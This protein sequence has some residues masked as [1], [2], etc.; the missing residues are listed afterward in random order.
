[1]PPWPLPAV[2]LGAAL[3]MMTLAWLGSVLARD[4]S[5]VDVFWGLGFVLVAWV[6]RLGL[7]EHS[8][9]GTLV[10]GLVT[11]WGVRLALH[12]F[13]RG[14]GR[15][16]DYR[17]REMRERRP[18]FFVAW[19]LFMVFWLQAALLW[20]VSLPLYQA[21]R[22]VEPAP[23]GLLDG[24]GL[25]L[26]LVGFA[27]E[28]VGDWQL[29]RFKRDPGNEG[30]VMDRGLWRYTRHP[31]Y[32]GDA[33]VWWGFF[34]FAAATPG[35]WWTVISPVLMTF[36]LLRVSGV[37]LLETRLRETRPGYR[38]YAGRTNA[39]FPWL[40]SRARTPESDR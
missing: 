35:G 8:L 3:A 4:A 20:L 10:V 19:S 18:R 40:P 22:P 38:A 29:A 28:A 27:F 1:M 6:Y 24:L 9:R 32:F 7:T 17:Y 26:F 21:Q 34:C 16:E 39:F 14:R 13:W 31:N 12:I 2:A 30:R 25:A 33:V 15:G 23:L 37:T 5:V 11:L 36:L